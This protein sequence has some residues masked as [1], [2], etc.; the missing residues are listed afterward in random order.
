MKIYLVSFLTFTSLYAFSQTVTHGPL[1]GGVTENSCRVFVRTDVATNI[2]VEAS[3]TSTFSA[4]VASSNALTDATKDNTVIVELTGLAANTKHYVRV[5]ISGTVSG[6]QAKFETFLTPGTAGHQVFLTGSSIDNLGGSDSLLFEQAKTE[7]AKAFIQTGNWGYPDAN[8]WF[9]IYFSSPPS[10]WAKTY[11]NVQNIY[12]QRYAS[13]VHRSFTKSLALDYVYDDHDYMNVMSGSGNVLGY[14]INIF[15]GSLGSPENWNMPSQARLNSILGYQDW[16]PGY[17]LQNSSEGIYHS[18]ISGNCEFFVLDTRSMRGPDLVTVVKIGNFWYYQPVA[19]TSLLGANQLA[20]LKNGLQN[21]TATWKFIVSS[22]PF[23][24]ANKF[25][26]DTLI[27]IGNGIVPYWNPQIQGINLPRSAFASTN[28][29]ADMWCGFR[30]EQDS[31]LSFIFENNI[32]NVFVLS[33]NSGTVGLDDGTNSGL[34]ELNCGNLKIANTQDMLTYQKFM[35]FNIWNRGGSGLCGNDN[36][37]PAYGRLEIFNSDS[38]RL[39]AVDSAGNEIM[40]AN[41]YVNTAYK[42]NPTYS[43]NA[44]PIA[45][46]DATTVENTDTAIIPV[47]SN[48]TDP[49]NEPLFTS[50]LTNPQNGSAYNSNNNIFYIPNSGFTGVDTFY[51]KLCDSYSSTCPNCDTA[52]VTVTVTPNTSVVSLQ[53][54]V[55]FRV[56]PNPVA[57][58]LVIEILN[59]TGEFVVEIKNILGETVIRKNFFSRAQLDVSLFPEGSYAYRIFNKEMRALQYGKFNIVR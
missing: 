19:G 24:V 49:D 8:G 55:R 57:N 39:S 43:P 3:T 58:N 28:H 59:S 17:N 9:D 26:L 4:I 52:L 48:D 31:L 15:S 33:G 44:F 7:K 54:K 1:I 40:A 16:F 5:T 2:V 41:F 21:S 6:D 22:V 11:S 36:F 18:F 35:R 38:I 32:R 46:N 23:N 12:K 51:Y 50:L 14:I 53:D 20:W 30:E 10:S 56:F 42:Y 37:N 34:P 29:F 25:A 27:K 45:F 13:N 47:V